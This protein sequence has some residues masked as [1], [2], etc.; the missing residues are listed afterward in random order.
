MDLSEHDFRLETDKTHEEPI[1]MEARGMDMVEHHYHHTAVQTN[2]YFREVGLV[3]KTFGW[4]TDTA[5][6]NGRWRSRP[7]AWAW[8]ALLPHGGGERPMR[9]MG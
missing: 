1:R 5:Y 3:I 4:G 8:G 2:I 7:M 9:S 6:E